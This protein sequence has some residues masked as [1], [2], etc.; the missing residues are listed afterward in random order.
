MHPIYVEFYEGLTKL[1]P[2]TSSSNTP[3]YSNIAY[4]ILAH[5]I[6]GMTN[7]PFE[8]SL[9]SSLLKPLGIGRTYLEH[10]TSSNNAVIPEDEGVSFWNLT[11]GDASP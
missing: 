7:K 3:V 4:Q 8:V 10:P 11:F 5:A 9:K 2:V 6:E 1:S